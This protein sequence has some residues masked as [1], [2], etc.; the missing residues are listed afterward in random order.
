MRK[1]EERKKDG[2]EREIHRYIKRGGMRE[3]GR[4]S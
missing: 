3:R 2:R 4:E 1:G